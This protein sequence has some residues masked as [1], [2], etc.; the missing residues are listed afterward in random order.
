MSVTNEGFQRN[1]IFTLLLLLGS[2]FIMYL[3]VVG[4][5]ENEIPLIHFSYGRNLPQV[6]TNLENYKKPST[7]HKSL[8]YLFT[9]FVF[10][11]IKR[12]PTHIVLCLSSY[13]VRCVA[14]LSELSTFD[15]PFGIFVDYCL[16]FC[17]FLLVSS[18]FS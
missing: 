16:P 15:C 10:V 18:F 14:S 11:S 13:F 2:M 1:L 8:T 17:P 5:K 4:V 7:Y 3:E 9:L 12:C 6:L